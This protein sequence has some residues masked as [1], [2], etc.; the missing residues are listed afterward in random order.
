MVDETASPPADPAAQPAVPTGGPPPP[1]FEACLTAVSAGA[2][3]GVDALASLPESLDRDCPALATI[4]RSSAVR[5]C[6]ETYVR[7]DA[8]AVR[9]QASLMQEATRAYLCLMGA[10]ITSGVVLAV[11]AQF[12]S[13]AVLASRVTLALGILTL[14]LGAAGTYFGY[15]ARDQGRVGRWQARRGEAEMARLGVFTTISGKAAEGSPA[16][17]LHGLAVI[18]CHLL[19]DQRR[20]LGGRALRHRKS[21]ELTSRFGGFAN[22]LAFVGGS[23]AIIASQV[24]DSVW[25]VLAGVFGAAM[26]AYATNRDALRR[27]R[28]NADRYEKA[29]VA[30]DGLAERTDDVAARI[31]T[32]EPKAL[33][34]FTEA[35]TELLAT[36]HK[37]WLEGTAQAEALLDKLDAQLKQLTEPRR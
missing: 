17:A 14:L 29:Q 32:G 21:S 34:A 30:L 13:A 4:L 1:R 33:V 31:A 19:N 10:G 15:L 3:S 23:G 9:Q 5:T 8:E 2:K 12:D 26:A 28:A 7:Q 18:V 11:A 36:E 35:V 27:D 22:A 25:V 24:K 6:L 16:V 37:Q 20:W